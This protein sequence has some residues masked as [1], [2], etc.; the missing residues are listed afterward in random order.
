[1]ADLTFDEASKLLAYDPKTG[2]LT[3]KVARGRF[4]NAIKA[5]S[6]AGTVGGHGYFQVRVHGKRYYAH[7][8]A[9][10]MYTGSWPSKHLDHIN[11][12]KTDNRIE[13]LRECSDAQN[14]QNRGKQANNTS[15]VQGVC[16]HKQAKKWHARIEVDG[17]R[18]N[19]G[20]FD[21][22]DEAAQARAAAKAQYHK[23]QPID[24]DN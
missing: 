1:M 11:G 2:V 13:N 6:V 12:Q 24:R 7:R 21:T 4:G 10:L 16:W 15:G 9:W 18:I 8:L 19:L 22:V 23:F 17:K 20:L 14:Q 5:G 3:W